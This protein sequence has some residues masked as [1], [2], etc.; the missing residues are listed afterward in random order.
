MKTKSVAIIGAGLASLSASIY[1]RKFGFKVDV[2]EQGKEPWG[3][4]A[5][6]V[7]DG[8]RFDSGL[9]LLTMPLVLE[10]LFKLFDKKSE[11]YLSIRKLESI[12]KY[13][14]S[15]GT[16]LT[17]YSDINKLSEEIQAKTNE[18]VNS[19]RKYFDYSKQIYDLTADLFLK[20]SFSELSSFLNFHSL[21]TLFSVNKIDAFRTMHQANTDFFSDKRLVQLF[22]RYTTY[23]GSNPFKAPATLNIIQHV[24]YGIGGY[25]PENGIADIPKSLFE[26]AKKSG[27]ISGLITKSKILSVIK[28]IL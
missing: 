10:D 24:E 27:L 20:K 19:I 5:S 23:N 21:K 9:T 1:L 12:C 13:F 2:F 11:N 17:A 28:I 6:V 4:A 3:K 16:E 25:L 18:N 14:F 22:D 7:F 8:F 26:L 15:D